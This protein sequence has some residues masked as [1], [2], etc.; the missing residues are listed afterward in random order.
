MGLLITGL[1][2]FL[3]THSISI[4]SSHLRDRLV[5]KIGALAWQGLYSVIAIAGFIMIVHGFELARQG[6]MIL[7][8]PP[9]WT[10]HIAL[11][12]MVFVFPLL[13]ATY[14]PGRIK[15]ATKHPMLAATKIWA[16]AHL[17]ANGGVADVVLFGS[18]LVWAVVDRISMKRRTAL[19]VP[20]MPAS[21]FNDALAVILGLGLYVGFLFGLHEK[22][23][24]VSP[25]G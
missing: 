20:G 12:L 21:R 2:L 9:T 22:L 14:L 11:L 13:F 4:F 24:G 10:R 25:L 18:L 5:A 23:F 8:Q 19:P 6:T 7:Y 17:L 1:V 16:L 15:T 3:G